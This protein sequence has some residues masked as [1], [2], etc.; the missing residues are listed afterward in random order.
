MT[1]KYLTRKQ[2]YALFLLVCAVCGLA[3]Y[4]GRT[5]TNVLATNV[6]HGCQRTQ[7]SQAQT[8][9]S[10]LADYAAFKTIL[11]ESRANASQ[12][13]TPQERRFAEVFLGKLQA[14]VSAKSWVPLVNCSAQVRQFGASYRPPR[15]IPFDV[16]MPPKAD[17]PSP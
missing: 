11:D 12:P 16:R 1:P 14:S 7:V 15:P 9:L 8:N 6:L 5:N 10:Q 3:I 4:L 2:G 13:T 17:L